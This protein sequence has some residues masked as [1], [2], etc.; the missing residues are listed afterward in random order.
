MRELI[1]HDAGTGVSL[2]LQKD[3]DGFFLREEHDVTPVIEL[4][5]RDQKE[6]LNKKAD[7]WHAA[8]VP[9]GIQFEW[10]T[11]YGVDFWNPA[12]KAGVMRLLNDPEYRYLRV[13]HFI[14]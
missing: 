2:Y 7:M 12:H 10:L 14:I 4:N 11:K 1:D 13:N 8:R 5:K 3:A 6:S 9:I